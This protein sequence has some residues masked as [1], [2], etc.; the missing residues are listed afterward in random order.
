MNNHLGIIY[1]IYDWIN[2]ISIIL[3]SDVS[4]LVYVI[5][6]ILIKTVADV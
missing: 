2:A 3:V 1:I 5:F 4:D 6:C